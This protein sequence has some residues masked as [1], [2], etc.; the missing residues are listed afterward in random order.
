[1]IL[2]SLSLWSAFIDHT[3]NYHIDT[4][5][6]K[7]IEQIQNIPF[8]KSLPNPFALGY[9]K[10]TLWLE[11]TFKN[12]THHTSLLLSLNEHFYEIAHL[13][14]YNYSW[15]QIQNGFF[16]PLKERE[17]QT[18][19][20]AFEVPSTPNTTQKIY[21]KLQ[22]KYSYFGKITITPKNNF[23]ANQFFSIESFYLFEFGILFII[24][25]SNLFLWIQLREKIYGFYVGYSFFVLIYSITLSGFLVYL[26]LQHLT[27]IFQSS[28]ALSMF[29]LGLFSLEFF[30]LKSVATRLYWIIIALVVSLL[31]FAFLQTLFY[32]PWNQYINHTIALLNIILIFSAIFLYLKG[33]SYIKYY[34]VALLIFFFFVVLFTLMIAGQLENTS[35]TRYGYL[36]AMC[37]ETIVFSLML[38]KRYAKI[39]NQQQIILQQEIAK[40]TQ[41]LTKTNTQLS[42]L[43]KE[44]E[45]LLKEVFH[46]V[47]NNFHMIMAFLWFEAKKEG[48]ENRFSELMNRIQSMSLI[49]EYLCNSDNLLFVDT[50]QY[51]Q[52]LLNIF[53][54]SYK[55]RDI[56]LTTNIDSFTLGFDDMIALS[57]ILNEVINNSIKHH[58]KHRQ[59]KL[60]FACILTQE[61]CTQI[62]IEDSGDG[63]DPKVQ[64]KG[65]G[66]KLIE[67]FTAKLSNG[68][69]CFYGESG[70]TFELYFERKEQR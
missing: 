39:K 21:L 46:R 45:L 20:L 22:G 60:T 62:S 16:L 57:V 4:T 7:N 50:K 63:F 69:F 38:A 23:F 13:Y 40:Q 10:D 28:A 41:E 5:N 12:H 44:R 43:V 56:I 26:D 47:K 36:F 17:I 24:I 37:F 34:L 49:H 54:N 52:N 31:V 14:Y 68:R 3:I 55:S 59:I 6:S 9:V 1:M 29:F 61:N 53:L 25:M 70:M 64:K 11:I 58:P 18:V 67:D 19:K 32:S 33:Q 8:E 27:Y 35:L 30:Q 66:L 15:K 51:L 65:F 48:N 2:C 42:L